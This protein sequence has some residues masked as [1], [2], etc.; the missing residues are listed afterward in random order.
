MNKDKRFGC[1]SILILELRM[2]DRGHILKMLD[3]HEGCISLKTKTNNL[4]L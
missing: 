3:I 2:R 4:Q 1:Q